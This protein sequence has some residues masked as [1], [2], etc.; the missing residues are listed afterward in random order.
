MVPVSRIDE[1]LANPRGTLPDAQLD[2]L[3][4]DLRWRGISVP[5][6]VH[7]ADGSGRYLLH[8]GARRLRAASRVG[9]H[10]VPVVV[11][12]APADRYAPAAE[13]LKRSALGPLD[14]A[15]SIR[16]QSWPVTPM[17]RWAWRLGV[18]LATVADHLSPLE[19]P[20]V[21]TDAL[22]SGRCASPRTL[23]ELSKL[24]EREPEDVRT[25]IEGRGPSHAEPRS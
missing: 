24:N 10:E 14:L 12:H 18:N 20:P 25:V 1:D 11:R 16:Q 17:P 9:L 22:T 6:V 4:A 15:R 5:L 2:E 7:P 23:H 3:A 19:L 8:F 21:L 13:N